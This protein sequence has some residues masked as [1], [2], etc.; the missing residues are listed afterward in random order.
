M[1]K[2]VVVTV[3]RV[4]R[5]LHTC[6]GGRYTTT[7]AA[8]HAPR[9]TAPAMSEYQY[10][11]HLK[12]L[13]KKNKVFRS[14]IGLGYYSNILP[15]VIQR[16]ILENPGFDESFFM[17]HSVRCM[18]DWYVYQLRF[19]RVFDQLG[20]ISH[21][22]S[23]ASEKHESRMTATIILYKTRSMPNANN[24]RVDTLIIHIRRDSLPHWF[25]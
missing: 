16:N 7:V 1:C 23:F 11:K 6:Q 4:R 10:A 21:A 14:Y 13:G 18:S 9:N 24:S 2:H 5:I 19:Q 20:N 15:A 17:H 8:T 22:S 3:F 12:A 25:N